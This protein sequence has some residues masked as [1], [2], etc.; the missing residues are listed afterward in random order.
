M[1]RT[2]GAGA[3]AVARALR[4][5][6]R[7]A[8]R[9]P[10]ATASASP[11]ATDPARR[12]SPATP[13]PS[14]RCWPSASAT[15]VFGR[16]VKVDVASHSPHMDPLVPGAGRRADRPRAPAPPRRACTRRSTPPS[17]R[18]TTWDGGVLGSQPAPA[19]P[20][21]RRRSSACWPTASTPSSRSD[22]TRRCSA[23]VT[24][25]GDDVTPTALGVGSLRRGAP[26]R[27]S[28][29]GVAGRA[30][31]RGPPG[32]LG[33][34]VPGRHLPP[35]ARCRTTRGSAQRHWAEAAQPVSPGRGRAG[36]KALDDTLRAGSTSRPGSRR[37]S[38]PTARRR[39]LAASSARRRRRR[40]G[41][42]GVRRPRRASVHRRADRPSGRPWLAGRLPPTVTARIGDRRR[43]PTPEAPAVRRRRVPCR[44]CRAARPWA[45]PPRLWWVTRGAHVVAGEA[46]S[47]T[48]H[49][50]GRRLGR[51]ARDG[52]RA[53]GLVG[54]S[55]RPRSRTRRRR[56]GR[57][58]RP[59][60]SPPTTRTRSPSGRGHGYALRLVPAAAGRAA[61]R[62]PS[63]ADRRCLPDHRRSRRRRA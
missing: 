48:R 35:G 60:T 58:P 41:G 29:A 46:P 20:A 31:G 28:L 44:R 51:G 18:A 6:G 55:G 59:T 10:T 54:R 56:A 16:A 24:E 8:H 15:E 21:S 7:G 1:Q 50:A 22:P 61:L 26:E 33:G 13:T 11:S 62:R 27:A 19:G 30:L 47:P 40:C 2:S 5:G 34:A 14:P 12:S 42:R 25:A 45:R 57:G 9:R 37:R 63:L 32:A 39:R 3:M 36:A 52:D 49:R 53:P 38:P 4:G 23:S 43:S 17:P